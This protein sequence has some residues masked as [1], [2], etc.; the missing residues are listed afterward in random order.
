LA[1]PAILIACGPWP[2]EP[3]AAPIRAA[4]PDRPIHVWPDVGDR[5]RIRYALVWKPPPGLLATL[6]GLAAIFSLGAGV[7]HVVFQEQ[8]P[9]VPIVRVVSPDLTQRMTEWVT[10]QVLMHHRQQPAYSRLQSERRWQGLAQPAAAAMRVGIMGL[11]ELGAAAADILVRLG[12]QVA[13]WRRRAAEPASG[14]AGVTTFH[15]EDGLGPFLA[16]TDILVALLPLTSATRGILAMP[17]FKRLAR[18]GPLAGPVL[19]N[20]GRGGL[21]VEADIVDAIETGVLAGA[22][23]DVFGAEPLDPA[24]PLWGLPNVVVTPHVA[25]ASDPAAIAPG[26]IRGIIA[27]E[28]GAPLAPLVDRAAGY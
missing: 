4:D 2:P 12:F 19:I 9:D 22:S 10:L 14:M 6:P 3:W 16:R 8:L 21:Q 18:D 27:F 1:K 26:I 28:A 20:G 13:G 15:G 25:A 11:G 17:L 23:L 24:S 7:D 5:S